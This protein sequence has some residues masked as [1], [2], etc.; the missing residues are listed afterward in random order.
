MHRPTLVQVGLEK[1]DLYRC[2]SY[3]NGDFHQ[4]LWSHCAGIPTKMVF[5]DPSIRKLTELG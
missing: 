2:S 4:K 5:N 1:E 3:R